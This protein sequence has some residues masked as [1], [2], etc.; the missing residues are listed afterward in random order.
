MYQ[1]QCQGFKGSLY[2]SDRDPIKSAQNQSYNLGS[3]RDLYK[4]VC[5]DC[6]FLC[7]SEESLR[8]HKH[9]THDTR[10]FTCNICD[11]NIIGLAKLTS[12][13]KTHKQFKCENCNQEVSLPNKARHLKICFLR[14]DNSD[15]LKCDDC[16]YVTTRRDHLKK[17]M[18]THS[19]KCCSICGHREKKHQES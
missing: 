1:R 2:D 10:S 17:H 15:D 13:M 12:H 3:D 14:D 6:H 7:S 19:N 11:S 4:F 8:Q 9:R 18:K 16:E 5:K